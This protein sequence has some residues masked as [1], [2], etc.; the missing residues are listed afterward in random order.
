MINKFNNYRKKAFTLAE[1]LITLAI[2]GIVAALTIPSLI[3]KQQE[4]ETVSALKN[5][6]ST[7][8]N[9]YTRA[10]QENGTPDT[11]GLTVNGT[12]GLNVLAKM[13][14]Y[15]KL[16]KNC[17]LPANTGCWPAGVFYRYIKGTG[18]NTLDSLNLA[19]AQL[20]DGSPI[21]IEVNSTNCGSN[22]GSG[23]LSSTCAAISID[24][25][26]FKKP[27]Q[28][29]VDFFAFAI[30]KNGIVPMGSARSIAGIDFANHC[31]KSTAEGW[32]CT[33]WVVYNENLDYLHCNYLSWTGKTQCD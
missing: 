22:W 12:G 20:A 21:L 29:G 6:Y 17:G 18:G 2:I 25:N 1:V 7:F 16:S 10:V 14:P 30:T 4:R 3:Q 5:A 33:A 26:G 19:K 24:T 15:L 27:N 13:A 9:A 28:Y 11:W 8:S 32:G 31:I 23:A